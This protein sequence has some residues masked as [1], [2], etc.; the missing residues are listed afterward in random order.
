MDVDLHVYGP[1][2]AGLCTLSHRIIEAGLYGYECGS[3]VL[4]SI[5]NFG[6]QVN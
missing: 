3:A 1:V 5:D 6:S 2:Y 4:W